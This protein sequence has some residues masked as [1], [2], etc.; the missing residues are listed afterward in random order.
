MNEFA[1]N[2]LSRHLGAGEPLRWVGVPRQ[3]LVLR[4]SDA[5]LLPFGILWTVFVVFWELQVLSVNGPLLFKLWG[6]PFLLVGFYLLI[7]RF[8]VDSWHRT[9]TFY[10]LTDRRAI[11]VSGLFSTSVASIALK[12][13]PDITL[14]LRPDRS[15]SIFFGRP[16]F[17]VGWGRGLRWPGMG[18]YQPAAFEMIPNAQEVYDQV[19]KVQQSEK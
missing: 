13:L 3:G 9:K 17:P 14:K 12:S 1:R 16:A 7:G 10:G 19:L 5:Y 15:G 6:I 18:V 8:L 2:E 11:I 4:A